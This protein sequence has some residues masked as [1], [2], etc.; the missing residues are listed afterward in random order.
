LGKKIALESGN[1]GISFGI[2]FKF[3]LSFFI[4]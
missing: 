3:I 2:S 4:S 1:I